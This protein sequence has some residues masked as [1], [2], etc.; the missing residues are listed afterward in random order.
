MHD[1]MAIS[2]YIFERVERTHPSNN[3]LHCSSDWKKF[4]KYV[5][6]SFMSWKLRGSLSN[7]F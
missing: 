7:I 3:P 2:D 4:I 5:Q 6:K 1:E